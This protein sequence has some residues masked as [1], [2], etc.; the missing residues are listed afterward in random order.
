MFFTIFVLKYAA[1]FVYRHVSATTP[2][3]GLLAVYDVHHCIGQGGFATVVKALHRKEGT[4][5]AVKRIPARSLWRGWGNPSFT[6]S[7]SDASYDF[8]REIVVMERLQHEN[9]CQ[10]REVFFDEFGLSTL[11]TRISYTYSIDFGQA[12]YS[13]G[14]P[15]VTCLTFFLTR[16][17]VFVSILDIPTVIY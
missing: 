7:L 17:T 8:S 15:V 10:M 4:W 11:C 13:N 2:M 3:R 16:K 6:G 5:H 1:G 12:L 9:I 14:S